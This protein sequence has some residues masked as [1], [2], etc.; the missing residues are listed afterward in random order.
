MNFME[1]PFKGSHI[2]KV[3]K[4]DST[5]SYA[6]ALPP[7]TPE[8]SI[9]WALDQTEGRGQ[10][11]NRWESEPGKNLTFSIILY[12][13]S[14]LVEDQFY[15]SKVVSLAICDFIALFTDNVSIKWPNDIYV[16][17][18]KIAGILIE[19]SIE[20]ERIIQSVAGIGVN[21]NQQTFST[22][23]PNPLSLKQL[24]GNEYD[25]EEMLDILC[26]MIA[27]RYLQLI[28]KEFQ[29]INENYQNF[30]YRLNQMSNFIANGE[31]FRGM[32]IE[33]ESNGTLVI[34]EK[35]KKVRKF[36]HK[37]VEYML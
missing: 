24:T 23:A 18:G 20:G 14:L 11:S 25:L 13:T 7:G 3:G 12:P 4:V 32:I 30:L 16:R 6:S 26:D 36:L 2:F 33:V 28:K 8:G 5:N 27:Y 29:I 17:N 37:E 1:K 9:V 19:N 21:I 22:Y 31:E 10:G 34:C 35:N 15:L